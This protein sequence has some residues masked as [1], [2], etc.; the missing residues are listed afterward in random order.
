MLTGG[1][2]HFLLR[3]E[4]DRLRPLSGR[5][6]RRW[7]QWPAHWASAAAPS[8]WCPGHQAKPR[9]SISPRATRASSR[10]CWPI[11]A[12]AESRRGGSRS[13]WPA[14][15]SLRKTGTRRNGTRPEPFC[16]LAAQLRQLC[17]ITRRAAQ[18]T[19]TTERRFRATWRLD[20]QDQV[21]RLFDYERSN[22]PD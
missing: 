10:A 16:R 19:R 5:Q 14:W 9:S 20:R 2:Q 3:H 4:N 21:C 6:R 11:R 8:R 15:G 22:R 17:V 18:A 13:N 1:T 7:T 12:K